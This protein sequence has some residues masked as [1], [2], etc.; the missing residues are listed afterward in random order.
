MVTA[1]GPDRPGII[2]EVT[3]VLL[4]AGANIEDS[5][6]AL[7]GGQ[8][9]M[10]LIVAADS[11][12]HVME[13]TLSDATRRM[14]LIVSVRAVE[15]SSRSASQD[16]PWVLSVYG[17]DHPGIVYRITA[18]LAAA[19]VN[20]TDLAT[21]VAQGEQPIYIMLMELRI[22]ANVDAQSL[23]QELKMIATAE[24]VDISLRAADPDTF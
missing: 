10:M 12:P 17:A 21:H 2:A 22:P 15:E 7:L 14:G 8:F 16:A 6:S 20:V 19:A 1:V 13:Q 11:A 9:V 23:E 24:G 5:R 4:H 18:A 3:K